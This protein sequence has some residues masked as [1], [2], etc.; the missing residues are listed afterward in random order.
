MIEKVKLFFQK[1]GVIGI[2]V[3][4]MAVA[5]LVMIAISIFTAGR[6]NLAKI[7]KHLDVI[8]DKSKDKVAEI[9][10]KEITLEIEKKV[11]MTENIKE[12]ETLEYRLKVINAASDK[13]KR[14]EMLILLNKSI[15]VK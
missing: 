14:V 9:K 5:I 15:E 7:T 4:V 3:V 11:K 13:R 12:K 8:L 2:T 10:A 1:N 6:Y